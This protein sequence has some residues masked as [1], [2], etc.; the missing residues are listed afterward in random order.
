MSN[1][2]YDLFISHADAD[3]A[4]VEGYLLETLKQAGVRYHSE[5]AFTLGAVRILEFERA[6]QQSQ[7]TLL[8]LTS[9]YLADGFNQFIDILAQCYG[10]DTATWPVI[11]L[12][13]E[14]VNLPPRLNALVKLTATNQH[15]EE[16]AIKR[17]C[18]ELKRPVPADSPKPPCPYPGMVPFSENDS[19]RFFGREQEIQDL[20]ERLRLHPFVTVIGS[21]G[22]G[23]S[24]LVFAGLIPHL[25]QTGLFGLGKWLVR[26]MRPGETPLTTLK[27]VL[28]GELTNK[29]EVLLQLLAIQ[30]DAQRLL[31]IVDQLEELFTQAGQEAVP[32]QEVLLELAK[33]PNVYLILTVRADFYAD[34]MATL[35]WHK[36]QAHRLEVLPIDEVGLRQAILRPAEDVGVFVETA[37][38]ERL[39]TD[40]AG[41]PG[42]LPLIQETLVLL[43]ERVERRFLPLRAYEALVLP[44]S[45]YEIPGSRRRTGLQV[46]IARR[47]DAALANLE[48]DPEKQQA[49][50]RRIF[51]RLI[52]FGEG[53]ADTRRQQAIDALRAAGD[54]PN[55][56]NQTLSHLA[57]CRLLTLSGDEKNTTRKADIAHEALISGWPALQQWISERREVEQTRRRLTAKAEEWV[58]FGRGSS[59]LLDAVELAE[60]ERWLSTPDAEELGY[61][62]SLTALVT[63][64]RYGIQEAERQELERQQRELDLIRERLEQETKARKAAQTR[65][66]VA[67]IS[68][69][70]LSGL[71]IFAFAQNVETQKKSIDALIASAE[72]FSASNRKLD[73]LIEMIK[74]EKLLN[75]TM[76]L[77]ANTQTRVTAALSNALIQVGENNR[78]DGHSDWVTGVAFSPDGQMLASASSDRTIKLWNVDGS[79]SKTLERHQDDVLEVAFSPDRKTLASASL[80]NTIKLWSLDGNL[81]RTFEGNNWISSIS[82]SP[83]GQTLAAACADKT[84]K[85]W[86]VNDNKPPKILAG[87]TNKVVDIS[88]SPRGNLIASVS[89]DGTIRLWSPDGTPQRTIQVGSGK[90][91]GVSFSPNGQTIASANE[92]KTIKL[93]NLNGTLLKTLE[94]H[95]N[96]VLNVRFSPNG[97]TIAS[98]SS[99]GTVK[100]W[101]N[102]GILIATLEGHAASVSSVR[103]SPDGKLLAS[104][105]QDKTIRLWSLNSI[106]SRNLRHGGYVNSIEF[107]PNGEILVSASEDKTIKLWRLDGKPLQTFAENEQGVTKASFSPNGQMIVSASAGKITLWSLEGKRLRTWQADP[108]FVSIVR[109][110]PDGNMIASANTDKLA[111][112]S[113]NKIVKLWSVDGQLLQ[114]L[115]DSDEVTSINSSPDRK[116]LASASGKKVRLWS[117]EGKLLQTLEGHEQDVLSMSFSLDGNLLVVGSA[118]GKIQLWQRHG[119]RFQALDKPFQGHASSVLSVRFSPDSQTIAS[120]SSDQTIKLWSL[121]G[122]LL[123]TLRGHQDIVLDLNFS[124]DGKTLASASS[125]NTVILW[126]LNLKKLSQLSCDWVRDY[127]KTN[128]NVSESDR[129]LCNRSNN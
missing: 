108:E 41:E 67:V 54:D 15:E 85:L 4:W 57:I 75:Q 81:L 77:S 80:D 65:N 104:G 117:L 52:Q 126:N 36:I 33:T 103:F 1:V 13:L 29:A 110:S 73:A 64:S 42:V 83:N 105:S 97:Q 12:I 87:H 45:A 20:L 129:A 24:S 89:E 63:A 95:R 44:R 34:L 109:L 55:L 122:T 50:A 5:A 14:P 118:D 115:Q 70:L 106:E 99:D 68:S 86:N 49:I 53:R 128:S 92:D 113:T 40:A 82:F 71:T 127:L 10:L 26:S 74:A 37:L 9:A 31:L 78:F 76:W 123:Q 16:E 25:R 112:S 32:F 7:R 102:D 11:P 72:K 69:L 119:E 18:A 121:D 17:L 60:A 116:T 56:F 107:S 35:L 125:D 28:G 47:A 43:W 22:S 120:A 51:L 124:P 114:T 30:P 2:T 21:S 91:F 59:G 94:G 88:F 90:V 48:A 23:K 101:N 39:A 61:D 58:R 3:R 62:E 84:V 19:D 6:I 96:S 38:I 98:A 8:V 66:A 46:A 93:W 111:A 79:L 27:S 100:L